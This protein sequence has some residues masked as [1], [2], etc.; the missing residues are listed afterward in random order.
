MPDLANDPEYRLTLRQA[1]QA[2]EDFAAILAELEFKKGQ[3]SRIPTRAWLSRTALMVFGSLWASLEL[4]RCCWRGKR[5]GGNPTE[6]PVGPVSATQVEGSGSDQN[7]HS[8][9]V[10]TS[11]PTA[12]DGATSPFSGRAKIWEATFAPAEGTAAELRAASTP[13][14]LCWSSPTVSCVRRWGEKDVPLLMSSDL[15]GG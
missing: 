5:A 2:R 12:I 3:L 11:A 14:L 8:S 9:R 13:D 15:I 1:D 4:F 6:E 7:R 10:T